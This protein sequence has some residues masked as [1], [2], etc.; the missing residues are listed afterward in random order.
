MPISEL[1]PPRVPVNREVLEKLTDHELMQTRFSCIA[2]RPY[3]S[4]HECR[5]GAAG[6]PACLV[7]AF[8]FC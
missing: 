8:H 5:V 2:R 7:G 1:L 6:R 3:L 4:E